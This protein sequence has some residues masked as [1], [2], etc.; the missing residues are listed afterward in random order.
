MLIWSDF[1]V[2]NISAFNVSCMLDEAK[3]VK[4]L[5]FE[6]AWSATASVI[7]IKVGLSAHCDFASPWRH[8]LNIVGLCQLA[9]NLIELESEARDKVL[10]GIPQ[11][12]VTTAF[13][14]PK[15]A[16]PKLPASVTVS[17]DGTCS[18]Y[19]QSNC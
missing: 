18:V 4:A 6:K 13:L 2:E 11:A 19:E 7:F 5:P 8:P 16:Q 9:A 1:C 3:H 15:H 14:L 10:W 17:V 12:N